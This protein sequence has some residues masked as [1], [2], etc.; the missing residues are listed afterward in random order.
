VD[1]VI[2]GVEL[3]LAGVFAV[4]GVAKL[5]DLAGS[6]KAMVDFG[7]PERVAP[8]AGLLLPVAELA[9][10]AALVIHPLAEAGAIAALTL[11]LLFTVGIANAMLR[12][13]APDCNCFG[14]VHSEPVGR[15]TLL[16]NLVLAALAGLLVVRGPGP[17][18]DE[19][20]SARTATE[21]VAIGAVLAVL[22][23]AAAGVQLWREN[24]KLRREAASAPATSSEPTSLPKGEPE[25]LPVGT[26]APSFTLSDMMG[27]EPQSLESLLAPGRPLVLEFIDPTCGSCTNLL[28]A[29]SRWQRALA[30][31]LT[32]A[33]VTSGS[34]EDRADWE[35]RG[36]GVI[37]L[38]LDDS[39]EV[40]RAFRVDSTPTAIAISADGTV[41]S[42]A[43]GGIH[44]PEVLCRQ[45]IRGEVANG[46]GI[47]APALKLS[48][49][50]A[51]ARTI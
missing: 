36:E 39:N 23:L 12:G 14:Q 20:V 42:A 34:A 5:M 8:V 33:V 41:V 10:A 15:W 49:V 19:W 48:H 29:L 40:F 1:S 4:A 30:E 46:N 16:R 50:P 26:P 11:L 31:Q 28:P 2:I 51:A 37:N 13:R 25:G 18:I 17:A 24:R 35:E 21:V 9:T 47:A 43:A 32:I 44:M 3:F 27:G 22:A 45:L 38:L 7:V 6:R